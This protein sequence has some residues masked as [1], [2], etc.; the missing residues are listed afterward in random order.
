ME[1][2][3]LSTRLV[4]IFGLIVFIYQTINA[5]IKLMHPPHGTSLSYKTSDSFI[6]P[7][8]DFGFLWNQKYPKSDVDILNGDISKYIEVWLRGGTFYHNAISMIYS[9]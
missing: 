4:G 2:K 3:A 7:S 8:V 1:V 9:K 5:L 6:H